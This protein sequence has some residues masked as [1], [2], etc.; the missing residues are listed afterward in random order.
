MYARDV[1]KHSME[2]S[3][4]ENTAENVMLKAKRAEA[5]SKRYLSIKQLITIYLC[6]QGFA[7]LVTCSFRLYLIPDNI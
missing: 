1:V 6:K 2:P 7:Q 3:S 4:S 5:T